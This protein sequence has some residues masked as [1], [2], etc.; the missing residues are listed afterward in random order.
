MA[1][2]KPAAPVAAENLPPLA[3][4]DNVFGD[5]QPEVP[6]T[7]F[8]VT[9]EAEPEPAAIAPAVLFTADEVLVVGDVVI[10]WKKSKQAGFA[11]V[12]IKV[13]RK[14]QT[15]A[16][17]R[18]LHRLAGAEVFYIA[19][20]SADEADDGVPV[21]AAQLQMTSDECA[22]D[23]VLTAASGVG[24]RFDGAGVQIRSATLN[25]SRT[26]SIHVGWLVPLSQLA[27]LGLL[28]GHEV[29]LHGRSKQLGLL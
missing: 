11:D 29:R 2:K 22:Y 18:A 14:L 19:S 8:L 10:D 6:A 24:P 27:D 1:P 12:G 20:Q 25:T 28:E 23:F 16:E 26:L 21:S 15:T 13:R 7:S 17:A 4:D 5:V 3:D 9:P